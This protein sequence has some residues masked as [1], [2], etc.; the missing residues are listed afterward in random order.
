MPIP[1]QC[2]GMHNVL[3]S[4]LHYFMYENRS[5]ATQAHN[6]SSEA[7]ETRTTFESGFREVKKRTTLQG[8]TVQGLGLND[9]K[10]GVT[11]YT[12]LLHKLNMLASIWVVL[13]GNSFLRLMGFPG[14]PC[15]L[16]S[17]QKRREVRKYQKATT[18]LQL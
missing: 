10:E 12:W 8:C 6:Y 3:T 5:T 1:F 9:T 15:C 7:S 2:P 11:R 14:G 13:Y 17:L 16:T 18:Y 4:S